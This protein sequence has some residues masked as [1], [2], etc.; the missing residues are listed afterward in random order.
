MLRTMRK[1][2]ATLSS[3]IK[4]KKRSRRTR[5][6]NSDSSHGVLG[7]EPLSVCEVA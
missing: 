7:H 4:Q 3:K 2:R 5:T 6:T 1:K